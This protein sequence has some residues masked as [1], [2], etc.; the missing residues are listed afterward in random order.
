MRKIKRPLVGGAVYI[1][2]GIIG[3]EM[4]CQ[5]AP[6]LLL[7]LV[8]LLISLIG[9]WYIK[10]ELAIAYLCCFLLGLGVLLGNSTVKEE[11]WLEKRQVLTL[12]GIVKAS[13][14]T[15]Y[16]KQIELRQVALYE[17]GGAKHLKS[18]VLVGLPLSAT[19]K[20]GDLI[21]VK[22]TLEKPLPPMNPSD[23]NYPYYL[24]SKN[25]IGYLKGKEVKQLG[26]KLTILEKMQQKLRERIHYLFKSQDKGIMLA[27]L[28]GES[29]EIPDT[30]YML[31]SQM[32]VV[33]VLAIS[34]LH[35]GLVL[36]FLLGIGSLLGLNYILRY[37][38]AGC[39][40][41][42]YAFM[43]GGSTPTLRATVMCTLFIV[44]R[45]LWEQEDDWTSLA[46]AAVFLLL[47]A[48]YQLYQAGFQLSFGAVGALL[49]S[50]LLKRKW[51]EKGR[52]LKNWEISLLSWVMVTLV[53]S[54][55]LAYHFFEIPFL[56]QVFTPF[57]VPLFSLLLLI[58]WGIIGMS[59]FCMPLAAQLGD[60]VCGVL[61]LVEKL[62]TWACSWP[63][64]TWCIGRPNMWELIGYY[65]LFT[66]IIGYLLGY[67]AR[68]I[69]LKGTIL[70]SGLYILVQSLLP[71]PLRFTQLYVGQGDGMVMTTPYGE[72]W[73]IDGGN[74]GK[75]KTLER[76]IKYQGKKQIDALFVS[77][78]D[79]DHIGGV[80]EL[81]QSN[82]R[83]KKVFLSATDSSE[84]EQQLLEICEQKQVSVQRLIRGDYFKR[85]AL[86]VHILT[87][88]KGE[89][90]NNS[91][92][93]SLSCFIGYKQFNALW[94]GDLSANDEMRAINK[95]GNIDVLKIAHHGSRT[96]T[97][98]K[99][100]YEVKPK[101]AMISCGKANRFGH[102]HAEV[103][104]RLELQDI[105]ILRTDERGAIT[106][107]TDGDTL[108]MWTYRKGEE[109]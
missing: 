44:A 16:N 68:S 63:L 24:K 98:E 26:Y 97:H 32:G 78:S 19:I 69:Y 23:W 9:W 92:D 103:L 29:E 25:Q 55:L 91:N 11:S 100:L 8:F 109:E 84:L 48:P 99:T 95:L 80:L 7:L 14:E 90:A 4:V 102:P 5:K 38:V 41:W 3:G 15:S 101:Y 105:S 65:F 108:K 59:I 2:I 39:L 83:I 77:H 70:I 30:T 81:L 94:T 64:G 74:K 56:T 36:T 73:V 72:V 53:L 34:G 12:T 35:V 82:L 67:Y 40:I 75:G 96:S 49:L 62:A 45:C 18:N 47:D 1:V 104:R 28:G 17:K 85:G 20:E 106:F 21:E 86:E 57:L 54:P 60:A 50:K 76:F 71:I 46:I 31:Y 58:G 93:N 10:Y 6:F 66:L 13:K 52:R 33:H 27:L 89:R 42:F 43:M 87:P 88:F 51:E 22:G 37:S 79:L 61:V 107:E